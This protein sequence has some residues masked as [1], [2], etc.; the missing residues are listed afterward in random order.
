V[1]PS[2]FLKSRAKIIV[3]TLTTPAL[4]VKAK[5]PLTEVPGSTHRACL[6]AGLFHEIFA[7]GQ[8]GSSKEDFALILDRSGDVG[9]GFASKLG[10]SGDTVD[11]I[12]ADL[13]NACKFAVAQNIKFLSRMDL[14]TTLPDVDQSM[15]EPTPQERYSIPPKRFIRTTNLMDID[16][17]APS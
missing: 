6:D 4:S 16:C 12:T 5:F 8:S 10:R 15:F 3:M 14:D 9:E 11:C 17:K 1:G 2:S 13:L 7:Q